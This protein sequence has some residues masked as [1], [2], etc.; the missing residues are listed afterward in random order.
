VKPRSIVLAAVLLAMT[1]PMVV[2]AADDVG[3][4]TSLAPEAATPQVW[5]RGAFGRVLGS[6]PTLPASA[7]PSHT[8][9]GTFIREAPMAIETDVP[10]EDIARIWVVARPV[11]AVAAPKVLSHG[12]MEFAGPSVAGRSIITATLTLA[13]AG[14]SRHAWL[15]EVPERVGDHDTLFEIVPP[16]IELGSEAGWV[17]GAAGNGC[18]AYLCSDNGAAPIPPEVVPLRVRVGET[19]DVRTADGSGLAGWSG[20][21]EPETETA[22]RPTKASTSFSDPAAVMSLFGL[23]PTAPGEW[24]LLLRVDFDRERGWLWHAYRLTVES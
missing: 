23:E 14:S 18:Y 10:A 12:A 6:D 4:D 9:L 8:P 22:G 19:L 13:S 2:T 17:T 16:G 15:V 7:Y 11:A 21:L 3:P 1:I 24:V 20:R 5:L